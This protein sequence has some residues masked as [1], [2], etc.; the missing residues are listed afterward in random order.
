LPGS[1]VGEVTIVVNGSVWS[2]LS[3]YTSSAI[4]G[5]ATRTLDRSLAL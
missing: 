3:T 5:P 4:T 1:P 2:E